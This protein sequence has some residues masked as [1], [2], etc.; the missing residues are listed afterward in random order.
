MK[1]VIE[2]LTSAAEVRD[3]SYDIDTFLLSHP[4]GIYT[5]CR[6]LHKHSIVDYDSHIA[7][8]EKSLRGKGTWN[9]DTMT[10]HDLE[11][12]A[13]EHIIHALKLAEPLF[14][15]NDA[16]AAATLEFRCCVLS[17]DVIPSKDNNPSKFSF[18]IMIEPLPI[19]SE[20]S[21]AIEIWRAKRDTPGVKDSVWVQKRKFMK[22]R[23]HSE[24]RVNEVVIESIEDSDSLLEGL[25]SN[26]FAVTKSG[27]VVTAPEGTVLIGT[28]RIMVEEA[29][30]KLGI[31]VKYECPRESDMENWSG[32]FVTSTTRMVLEVDEVRFIDEKAMTPRKE[33]VNFKVPCDVIQ[34]IADHVKSQLESAST[35]LF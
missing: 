13:R 23:T 17:T 22:D 26:F 35:K 8:L 3:D 28:I 15:S 27:E 16:S 32:A 34:R 21:V 20:K 29:C 7:R 14:S 24:P 5:V 30:K 31:P 12:D 10:P 11:V 2:T 33:C 4:Q 9:D 18:A 6:T 19:V 25:S 1:V